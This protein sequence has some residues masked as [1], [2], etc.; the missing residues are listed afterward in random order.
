MR[1]QLL[2]R[3]CGPLRAFPPRS[4]PCAVHCMPA[5][6]RCAAEPIRG[7]ADSAP[8]SR[9]RSNT[10]LRHV[11]AGPRPAHICQAQRGRLPFVIAAGPMRCRP[12]R[13]DPLPSMTVQFDDPLLPLRSLAIPACLM[14]CAAMP[15][16]P[17][18]CS[19]LLFRCS[20]I[21]ITVRIHRPTRPCSSSG[22]ACRI[23]DSASRG[24]YAARASATCT[25]AAV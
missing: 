6:C 16:L 17:V 9:Y 10:I 24:G 2:P 21:P 14:P 7:K 18:P 22:T 5:V 15:L 20:P 25:G 12:R 23:S 19:P 8:R 3:R 1:P 4:L 13:R 11:S